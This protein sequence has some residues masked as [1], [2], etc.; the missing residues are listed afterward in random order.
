MSNKSERNIILANY[1]SALA[2]ILLVI[3]AVVGFY[4]TYNQLKLSAKAQRIDATICTLERVR[5]NRDARVKGG[6]ALVKE[7]SNRDDVLESIRD[8]VEINYCSIINKNDE[9][10]KV[11]LKKNKFA[12]LVSDSGI[13]VND[14]V[15]RLRFSLVKYLNALEN[16]IVLLK[17]K[18]LVCDIVYNLTLEN[19]LNDK[20]YR[21]YK[22]FI[23]IYPKDGLHPGGKSWAQLTDFIAKL[24]A[25][26]EKKK[27]ISEYGKQQFCEDVENGKFK[28][29]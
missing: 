19:F 25:R 13:I 15:N 27:E 5:D 16:L 23:D 20:P 21:N 8:S 14:D 28:S 9:A 12:F 11:E 22:P 4:F 17:E 29:T 24:E 10:C 26:A 7:F 2:Q 6:I 1:V 18:A 3:A